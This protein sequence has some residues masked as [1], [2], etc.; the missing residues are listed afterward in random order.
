[1]VLLVEAC[2]FCRRVR[3]ALTELDLTAEV[4]FVYSSQ[5][6]FILLFT[7]SFIPLSCMQIYPCPK[8][9]IHHRS[10]VMESGG[11]EQ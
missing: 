10:I 8:G 7:N 6:W 11:K 3:E 4:V 1:M 9:S 5:S 2:P